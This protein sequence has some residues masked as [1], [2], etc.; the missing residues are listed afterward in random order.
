MNDDPRQRSLS[1]PAERQ[2]LL[3]D[4]AARPTSPTC[5]DIDR[6]EPLT[7]A[8][9][10]GRGE[11]ISKRMGTAASDVTSPKRDHRIGRATTG[12]DAMSLLMGEICRL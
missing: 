4:R 3:H 6:V 5:R 12:L 2:Q 1:L 10:L 9:E 7:A 8:S 11:G